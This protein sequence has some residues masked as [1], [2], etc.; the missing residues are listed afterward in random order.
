MRRIIGALAIAALVGSGAFALT[1]GGAAAEPVRTVEVT[2]TQVFYAGCQVFDATLATPRGDSLHIDG[3]VNGLFNPFAFTGT[4]VLDS[5][6]RHDVTGTVSGVGLAANGLPLCAD[7]GDDVGATIDFE[8]TPTS[9][10]GRPLPSFQ[11]H[12]TWCFPPDVGGTGPFSGTLTGA[13]P[14]GTA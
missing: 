13:L 11:L 6:G 9:D 14:P 2:G 8:L 10:T 4:F 7:V 1:A 3:C 5:P 12:G